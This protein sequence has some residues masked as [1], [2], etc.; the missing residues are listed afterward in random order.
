MKTATAAS[1]D[2]FDLLE[3]C[4]MIEDRT[5]LHM[6]TS[7]HDLL[8]SRLAS[9]LPDLGFNEIG[10]YRRYLQGKSSNDP[11]WQIFTNLMT[12]NK[13][14]FFREVRHF[15]FLVQQILPAWLKTSQKV[16]KAW[17]AASS[18]GEE[19]YTLAMVLN[20]HLPKDRDFKILA[21]DIDTDVLK[22]ASNS[23]YPAT[24]KPEI[25]QEYQLS[26]IENGKGDAEGWFRMKKSLRDR[27]QFTTH[28]L[29]EQTSP[30]EEVFDLVLCRNVLI[31]FDQNT[32][33]FVQHKLYS[34]TKTGGHLFIGHSESFHGIQHKWKSVGP[35]VFRKE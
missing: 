32:I 8:R 19:A 34:T 12:T 27:I 14:D 28:N 21:T 16:F 30:G 33:N 10:E 13:T 7:K 11:E 17:S 15:E 2:E 3:L 4:R 35:S 23:V 31:Y 20:Q 9:R 25:P 26:S 22:T 29:I 6:K 1:G 24:K 18:T 5:G